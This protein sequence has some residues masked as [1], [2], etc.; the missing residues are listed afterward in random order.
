MRGCE[1]RRERGTRHLPN[2]ARF[3]NAN[4]LIHAGADVRRSV[5]EWAIMLAGAMKVWSS[6]RKPVTAISRTE[7]EFYSVDA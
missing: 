7:S 2:E 6:K 1:G 3:R 4:L 5:S